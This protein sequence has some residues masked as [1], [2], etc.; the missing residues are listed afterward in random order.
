MPYEWAEPVEVNFNAA[1]RLMRT[2]EPLLRRAEA[3][4]AVFVT[5]ARAQ[6]PKA[7]WAAYAS[8]KA[9]LEHLVRSWA[10]ELETTSVRVNLFAPPPMATRLRRDAFPGEIPTS[11]ASPADIAP[12]LVALCLPSER[13]TG[14]LVS[15]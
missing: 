14:T 11:L 3:G 9:G 7:Y 5:D 10:D 13:R 15:A 2:A 6:A 12:G 1:M 8:S 4:R